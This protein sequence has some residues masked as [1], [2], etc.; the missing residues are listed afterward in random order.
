[1]GFL[2]RLS[3]LE[4]NPH[5]HLE[6]PVPRL[7]GKLAE[8]SAA[9][10]V[11]V[12]AFGWTEHSADRAERLG[13]VEDVGSVD[14]DLESDAFP[15]LEPLRDRHVRRPRSLARDVVLTE[16]AAL[17]SSKSRREDISFLQRFTRAEL[18]TLTGVP[19]QLA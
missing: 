17:P 3:L 13:M 1:M 19:Q 6:R 4:V 14:A 11:Q 18:G 15:D 8:R 7:L 10:Y 5:L 9:V 16:V 12:G 2:K